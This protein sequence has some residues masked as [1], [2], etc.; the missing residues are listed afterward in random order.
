MS[1]TSSLISSL[2]SSSLFSS[3]ELV[4]NGISIPSFVKI[5]FIFPKASNAYLQ[6]LYKGTAIITTAEK[7]SVYSSGIVYPTKSANK[8]NAVIT[9]V[10]QATPTQNEISFKPLLINL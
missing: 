4:G 10:K 9:V 6:E 8:G 5:F 2:T 7:T 3:L 1:F